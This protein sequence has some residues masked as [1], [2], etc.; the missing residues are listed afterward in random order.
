MNKKYRISLIII[1]L[2]LVCTIFVATS[3]ALWSITAVQNDTNIV[4]TG[5][6]NA[7]LT[8]N[9]PIALSNS[10]PI[11]EAAGLETT[12]YTFTIT[13]TCS[14]AASY[15][16]T[17]ESLAA[18]TLGEEYL[19]VSLDKQMSS[20]YSGLENATT[21][22]DSSKSAKQLTNGKLG[23]GES[24]TFDLRLWLDYE[25]TQATTANKTFESKIIVI[26]TATSYETLAQ[27]VKLGD[28][29]NLSPVASS[30]QIPT[31][32]TG[33]S[34]VQTINP[35]ELNL[36]R[37]IKKNANGS[38]DVVSEYVS[39][40]DVHFYG[41][42]GYKKLAGSLNEI[43]AQYTNPKYVTATR[44]LGYSGQTV[45]LTDDT[46][47]S[48]TTVPFEKTTE[49]NNNEVHGGGDML[50]LDDYVALQT[51]LE[52]KATTKQ[53]GS[54]SA[55]Y[56]A[57]RNFNS[58][59][60]SWNFASK[61]INTSGEIEN[62]PLYTYNGSYADNDIS[63]SIR[64]VLTLRSSLEPTNGDGASSATAYTFE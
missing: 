10:Y 32:L 30:Y 63:S 52:T 1:T 40:V 17:L 16:V 19:R 64:P 20:L 34:S 27:K 37:V 42:E 9:N 36:W 3:Y 58:S 44:H 22:F 18:T 24:A 45:N 50:H 48:S 33:Y 15:E 62:A 29:I 12:P 28:Y 47:F 4:A 53:N 61:I 51:A 57:S 7:T 59:A 41:K 54:S 11:T 5:C 46:I 26:N 60:N 13:N 31:T 6:F 49:D 23:A 8:N 25:A 35:R 38:V 21:Y 14:I 2:M 43:A 39:N 55:Y 56:L